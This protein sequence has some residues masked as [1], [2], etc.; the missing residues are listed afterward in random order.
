VASLRRATWW[1]HRHGTDA[2]APGRAAGTNARHDRQ[3]RAFGNHGQERLRQLTV[4]VIGAGGAGSLLVQGLA[5]LGVGR[6]LVVDPDRVETSNLNRLVGAR[7][8]DADKARLKVMTA[9]R[10]AR[11]IDP[12]L[13]VAPL[14]SSVLNPLTWQALR[15]ADV[16]LG[17]V[18]SDAARWALNLLAVQYAKLYLDVGVQIRASPEGLEVA[19]HLAA[20]RPGGPC[21]RCLHGYDPRQAAA[22]LQPQLHATK[23]ASGYLTGVA[24]QPAP[25]VIFLNQAAVALALAELVNWVHPWKAPA[26]Y[27][28][29]DL[30][31]PQLTRLEADSDP[32]CPIC[33]PD[34]PRCL[35][36]LADI[37]FPATQPGTPTPP[38]PTSPP[39]AGH[40][41]LP[42]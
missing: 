2:S 18:D 17:A 29:V 19:G 37:P 23:R 22:E 14:A 3:V 42:V 31:R 10:M 25:S 9:S 41:D 12:D 21:L 33:G 34:G 1:S 16:L 36:D 27:L 32:T 15:C 5:H 24:D 6:M 28:L 30:A 35:G 13:Q 7:P 39:P 8:A 26:T 38:P 11:S 20:V 40:P 4:A